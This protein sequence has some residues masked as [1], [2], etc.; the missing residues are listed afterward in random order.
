MK[1][2]IKKQ[3]LSVIVPFLNEEKTLKEVINKVLK[4]PVVLE[5]ILVDDGSNDDYLKTVKNFLKKDVRLYKHKQN[6]GKGGAIQTGLKKVK[7]VFTLIQDADLEY[8]PKEYKK[9]LE[10][11]IDT[12]SDFVYG[13][14]GL[15]KG[16]IFAKAANLI[17]NTYINILLGESIKD[18]YT[19]YTLG[20]TKIWKDLNLK[21]KGFEIH[22]ELIVKLIK[23][24]YKVEEV[25]I[26]YNP[27]SFKEGKK[28]KPKDFFK[29]LFTL[30]KF[31]FF[32]P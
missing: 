22:S 10:K 21:S 8:N 32:K 14:R 12:N 9:L 2:N 4:Q 7:G 5:V 11:L 20:K 19:G 26:N 3:C 6:I 28:I 16:Y 18:A 24:N 25:F 15:K 13:Y 30:T 27:R 17:I 29:A 31:R 1:E 23:N